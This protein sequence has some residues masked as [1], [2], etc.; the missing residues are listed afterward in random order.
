MSSLVSFASIHSK[1]QT[2]APP[3]SATRYYCT[4]SPE[5]EDVQTW[6]GREGGERGE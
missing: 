6:G 3:H 5:I 2:I 1:D 4:R